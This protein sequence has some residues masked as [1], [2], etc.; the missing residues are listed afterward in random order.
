MEDEAILLKLKRDFTTNEAV[1]SLLKIVSALEIE[2]GM[3]KSELAESKDYIVKL[4]TQEKGSKKEWLKDDVIKQM[5]KDL[6]VS[7][8][9]HTE[10]K[11]SFEQWRQKYFTLLAQQTNINQ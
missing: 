11:K 5:N 3:L 6:E 4:K 8:K 7:Q 9:K 1:Q 2:V 10:Y